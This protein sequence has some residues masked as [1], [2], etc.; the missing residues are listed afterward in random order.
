MIQMNRR[1]LI[2][3][4]GLGAASAFVAVPFTKAF[5]PNRKKLNV[6][7][8]TADDLNCDSVGCFG[9]KVPGLTPNLDAFASEGVRFEYAHVTVAICQPSRGVLATGL[10]GHNSGVMGFMH[11]DRDI[12]TVM[13]TLADAGYLTGILGKV[14]H[15][16]PKADYKWDFAHDQKE[17]GNGRD[18]AIYYS[19][20]QEFLAKCR[21]QDKPFYFMVNSHDPHRPY[22][23]PGKPAKGAKEPSKIYKPDEVAVPGFVPDLPGVRTELSYYLNSTRRLDDT[24]GKTMQALK[25]SGFDKNTLVMFLSDNGIAIPFAKCNAYLASTRTP[26]IVRWPDVATQGAVEKTHFIS[27]I[28]FFPTVLEAVDLPIPKGLDG[29][30][31][32]PLL[33]GERQS[34]RDMVFTQIDMKAGG[35]AVPMRCVQDKRF[36]YIFNPWADGKFWYR[37][38]NEGLTMKA[39]VEAAKTRPDIAERVRMFRY[40]AAEELYE[41]KNDPD[42][43]DNLAG[44]PGFENELEERQGQ[45]HDWMKR[46]GDPLLPAFECRNSPRNLESALTEIYGENYTKAAAKG[47][48][49]PRANKKKAKNKRKNK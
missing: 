45:I 6:L 8:F 11:T 23:V 48:K 24:F 33:K 40:R 26:W 31:F 1:D 10:Y 41:F 32:L 36:G 7:L 28:D 30:S 47:P 39:M 16:T 14:K 29:S 19:Y 12:P 4:A 20:C 15:S 27:G 43:L 21:R 25:E 35:D 42:C 49:V 38:N 3:T 34:G 22:H 18:P 44:K 2:K 13:Q 17:L 9:G 37:N 46:T 5:E